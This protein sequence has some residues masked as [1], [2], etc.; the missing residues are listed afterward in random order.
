MFGLAKFGEEH[1]LSHSQEY[2]ALKSRGDIPVRTRRSLGGTLPLACRSNIMQAYSA[3]FLM[4]P[5][6]RQRIPAC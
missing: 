6:Y 4:G 5:G 1:G 3:L 2:S